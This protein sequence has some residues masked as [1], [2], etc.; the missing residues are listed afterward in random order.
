MSHNFARYWRDIGN[1]DK[2]VDT[3]SLVT[4]SDIGD[5]ADIARNR[6]KLCKIVQYCVISR[7]ISDINPLSRD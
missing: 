6:A 7:N 1:I 5:I 3:S 2:K 4:E